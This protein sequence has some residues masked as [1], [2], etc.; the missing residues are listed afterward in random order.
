MQ[1]TKVCMQQHIESVD[2]CSLQKYV[3][4]NIL[5]VWMQLTKVCMQQHIESV[6]AAYKSMYA[7]TY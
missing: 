4:R 6:D 3:C 1:L 5:K 2:A 7:A